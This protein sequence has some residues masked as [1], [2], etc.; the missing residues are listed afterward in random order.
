M[1]KP[2]KGLM[3]DSSGTDWINCLISMQSLGRSLAGLF[4]VMRQ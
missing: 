2:I 4:L 3:V 1:V